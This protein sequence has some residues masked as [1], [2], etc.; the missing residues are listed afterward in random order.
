VL[1][2]LGIAVIARMIGRHFGF[3]GLR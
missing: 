1:L 3:S 2:T